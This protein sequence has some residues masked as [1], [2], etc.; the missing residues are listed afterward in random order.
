M[1]I[2][3]FSSVF[4]SEIKEK[5]AAVSILKK[6]DPVNSSKYQEILN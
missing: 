4:Q 5:N 2:V 1:F 3:F 6:L